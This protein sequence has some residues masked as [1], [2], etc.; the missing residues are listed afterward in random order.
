MYRPTLPAVV[1]VPVPAFEL[2]VGLM[3]WTV[4]AAAFDSGP[5]TVVLAV[6]LVVAGWLVLTVRRV[7]GIGAP[8]PR[9]GRAELL[10]RTG[11]TLGLVVALSTALA[12]VGSGYGELAAPAACMLVGF[13]VARLSR[14]LGTRVPAVAGTVLV[15]LGLAGV[16]L[17]LNTPGLLYGQGLVGLGAAAVLWLAGTHRT[18]V[19]AVPPGT[20]R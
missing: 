8:L 3:W 12:W 2:W 4:G 13:A 20:R 6:G 17:A 11:V 5:G 1:P 15:V 19:L 18:K 10:R 9:G 14:L 7:H 16:L